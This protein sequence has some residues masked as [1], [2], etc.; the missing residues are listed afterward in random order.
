LIGNRKQASPAI[1]NAFLT[2]AKSDDSAIV[3]QQLAASARRLPAE[4]GLP[5]VSALLDRDLD[6]A[7]PRTMWSLWWAIEAKSIS[8]RK[9]VLEQFTRTDGWQNGSWRGNARRLVRRYAAEGIA[10]GYDACLQLLK[11]A[12]EG[13]LSAAHAALAQGLTERAR[14]LGGFGTGGL[15]EQLAAVEKATTK[16]KGFEPVTP[17]LRSYIVDRWQVQ[18]TDPLWLELALLSGSDVALRFLGEQVAS[19]K[20]DESQ[21]I[22]LLKLISEFGQRSQVESVVP[23]LH[24]DQPVAVRLAAIDAL[25]RLAPAELPKRLLKIYGDLTPELR[26]KAREALLSHPQAAGALLEA[27]DAGRIAAADVPLEQLRLVAV[28]NDAR[29]DE[30]VRKH[31]GNIQP[32][33]SEEKLA[34][35]RRLMN[36]L[37]AASGDAV[38]GKALFGKHC[39]T[40]HKLFGEGTEVGPDLTPA[41]RGDRAALLANIVDPAAVVRRQYVNYA[42]TTTAGRVL[43]GLIADQNAASI[44]ILDAKNQRMVLPRDQ[45][46]ELEPADTSLMPE[47]LLEQLSPQELR[48]LFGYLERK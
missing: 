45:I 36:D 22:K 34:T 23:L 47:R 40:C 38:R 20:V 39:G 24:A 1:V 43:T 31:W 15:F 4:D 42:I 7:D 29:L 16:A 44:T 18:R 30:L 37:R 10:V 21:R 11:A 12:P 48:D 8:D 32:G 19:A 27:V 17:E 33:T 26:S 13:Q 25:T 14:G 5:I 46:E 28:H 35:M 41:N 2:L 9:L 3:R 6:D